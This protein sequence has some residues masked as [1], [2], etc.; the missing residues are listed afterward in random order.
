M[1]QDWNAA[2]MKKEFSIK[3]GHSQTEENW[4]KHTLQKS[5]LCRKENFGISFYY[6]GVNSTHNSDTS[7][8]VIT[9]VVLSRFKR[10]A[11]VPLSRYIPYEE[12]EI[13]VVLSV[14]NRIMNSHKKAP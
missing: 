7:L 8:T 2:I 4:P 3:C 12:P 6:L 1:Q 11:Q 10:T 5:I 9:G 14:I 13:S